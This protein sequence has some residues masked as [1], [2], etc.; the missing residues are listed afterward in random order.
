[1]VVVRCCG[2]SKVWNGGDGYV[3][4]GLWLVYLESAKDRFFGVDP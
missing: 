3:L 2:I 4:Q 1:M